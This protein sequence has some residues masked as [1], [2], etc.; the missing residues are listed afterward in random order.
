MDNAISLNM[1]GC[2]PEVFFVKNGI[3]Q[4]VEGMIGGTK[5]CPLP[6]PRATADGFAVQ[7]DNVAAEFNIPPCMDSESFSKSVGF[8]LKHLEKI[9]K[10]NKCSLAFVPDLDFPLEQ[11]STPHA[12]LMGC[13][14]D[15]SV[16]TMDINPRP[17]APRQ[18]RTAAGHVHISWYG[19]VDQGQQRDVGR[20]CDVYHGCAQVASTEPNRRRQLYGKAGCI[21]PKPWGIE[22]RTL[23]NQWVGHP[24]IRKHVFQNT[25]RM[26]RDIQTNP[27][28]INE[29]ND[30]GEEIQIAINEHNRDL[31]LRILSLFDVKP[32]PYAVLPQ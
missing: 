14:P 4:S 25:V 1:V 19:E 27:N 12:L 16:W 13:D 10:K 28:L 32:Y 22:Y 26:F 3:P 31:A 2:D 15:F 17:Q 23:D 8:A 30:W 5:E 24:A 11:V 7:E 21:R 29:V 18:M 20:I 6:I 9:A